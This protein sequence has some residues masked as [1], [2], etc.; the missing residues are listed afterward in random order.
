MT[1]HRGVVNLHDSLS[2]IFDLKTG[3]D[4]VLL[5]FSNFVFDHF[6]E[7]MTDGILSGQ[8]LVILNDEMRSDK[9]RLYKYIKDNKVTYLSGTPSVLSLYEY[10]DLKSITRIDAVGE[11][12][13]EA[14]FNKIRSNFTSGIIINGYGPTEVSITTHKRIY[15]EGESRKNKSIGH[16]IYNSTC[17]IMNEFGQR[18]PIGAVGELHLGGIGVG[19]GYLNREDLTTKAFVQNPFTTD[20]DKNEARNLRIYKTGDL[21]RFLPCG[22]VECLGRNDFQVSLVDIA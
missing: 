14:L 9:E 8:T 22:E 2:K 3:K 19:R 18:V 1:E 5:S 20:D 11:D 17:Y 13:T 6:V 7:Q 15:K 12:F 4:E 21:A 10:E 16:Q